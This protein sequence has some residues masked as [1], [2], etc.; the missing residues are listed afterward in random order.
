MCT[1]SDGIDLQH[2][3][4]N[5]AYN[6]V[7]ALGKKLHAFV[8]VLVQ[9]PMNDVSKKKL[10]LHSCDNTSWKYIISGVKG[11]TNF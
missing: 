5:N 7:T 1:I 9:N 4:L 8:E 11:S 6:N 2:I 3:S 10:R